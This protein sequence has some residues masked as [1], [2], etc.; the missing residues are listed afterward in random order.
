MRHVLCAVLLCSFVAP[1]VAD[2]DPAVLDAVKKVKP[3]DYPS[4]NAVTI[5]SSQ[6]RGVPPKPAAASTSGVAD[7]ASPGNVA[8]AIHCTLIPYWSDQFGKDKLFARQ[9]SKRGGELFC[10][11]AGDRVRIGGNAVTY[12]KGEIYVA[13]GEKT[14]NA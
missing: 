6:A 7:A 9:V 12:L 3:S 1:A 11:L 8:S 13:G 5:I 14:A 4:A 2:V 10:E